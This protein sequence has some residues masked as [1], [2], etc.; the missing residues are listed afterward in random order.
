MSNSVY[1]RNVIFVYPHLIQHPHLVNYYRKIRAIDKTRQNLN[2]KSAQSK[3]DKFMKRLDEP[4][5]VLPRKRSSPDIK[6]QTLENSVQTEY[7]NPANET[8]KNSA[9]DQLN[10]LFDS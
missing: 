1:V 10:H 3:K 4:F 9:P 5:L 6:L 8:I 7:L 2:A